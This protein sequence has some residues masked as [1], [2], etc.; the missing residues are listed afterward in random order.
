MP[1][2]AGTVETLLAGRLQ[3]LFQIGSVGAR[4]GRRLEKTLSQA[5]QR[6]T[7]ALLSDP[8]PQR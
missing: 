5:Y 1:V 7:P 4:I 2:N 3:I 8:A 6:Q